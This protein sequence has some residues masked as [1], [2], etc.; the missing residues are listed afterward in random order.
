MKWKVLVTLLVVVAAACFLLAN[1]YTVV[2]TNRGVVYKTD[3]LT[4]RTWII[5]GGEQSLIRPTF[6]DLTS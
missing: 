2:G 3:R 4:G 6:R 5:S 1:R